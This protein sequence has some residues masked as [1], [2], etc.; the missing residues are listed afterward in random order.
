MIVG[1][2]HTAYAVGDIDAALDFYVA[3]LGLR[4]AFRLHSAQGELWIVYLYAGHGTFVELFPSKEAPG[5]NDGSYRH[6]CLE[7]DDMRATLAELA[8]RG[9]DIQG[10]ARQGSDKNL[11]YWL[12]DP[13]GNRIELMEIHPESPQAAARAT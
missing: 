11:Q 10:E 13:D 9:L 7:V 12:T 8:G 3:K 4:E 2:G 5:A 6:L 1:I